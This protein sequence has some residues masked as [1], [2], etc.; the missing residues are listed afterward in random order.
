MYTHLNDSFRLVPMSSAQVATSRC[1][2]TR[3]SLG[4]TCRLEVDG[5]LDDDVICNPTN[6]TVCMYIYPSGDSPS[7]FLRSTEIVVIG[8][9]LGSGP[10]SKLGA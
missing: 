8:M 7:F 5:K 1:E 9:M 2:L 10:Q 3:F 6:C 4:L